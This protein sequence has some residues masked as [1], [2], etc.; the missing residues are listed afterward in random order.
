MRRWAAIFC[1]GIGFFVLLLGAAFAWLFK[2]GLG[3]DAVETHGFLG[4]RRLWDGM[5]WVLG[6]YVAPPVFTGCLLYPWR[7]RLV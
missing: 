6:L 5:L 7:K 2:D 1:W 3:P 4:L